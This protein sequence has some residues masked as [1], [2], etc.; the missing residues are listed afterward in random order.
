M[1]RNDMLIP[2]K[3]RS[4]K[5]NL[6]ELNLYGVNNRGMRPNSYHAGDFDK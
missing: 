4:G 1:I 3:M 2:D 5:L 6:A